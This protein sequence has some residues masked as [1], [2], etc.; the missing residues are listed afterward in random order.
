[1][2]PTTPRSSPKRPAGEQFRPRAPPYSTSVCLSHPGCQLQHPKGTHCSSSLPLCVALLPHHTTKARNP[3]S[4][5]K[6]PAGV[7]FFRPRAPPYST[8][9]CLSHP[10]GYNP[11][12]RHPKGT[13][14]SSSLL[15][16]SV[17]LP[18]HTTKARN[19]RLHFMAH[20]APLPFPSLPPPP[21]PHPVLPLCV[22]FLIA[23]EVPDLDELTCFISQGIVLRHNVDTPTGSPVVCSLSP[24]PRAPP[25]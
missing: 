4:S 8:S 11:G 23:L 1:M 25:P 22:P 9:V 17:F 10:C 14:C 6:R 19:S 2:W 5:P 12:L 24:A 18:H 3:R 16:C 21:P 15:L 20:Y 7:F 13:Q